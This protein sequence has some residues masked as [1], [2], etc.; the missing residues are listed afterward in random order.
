LEKTV[1]ID[2]KTK[3]SNLFNNF[4]LEQLSN[5]IKSARA[6]D[7]LGQFEEAISWYDIAISK[8][9]KDIVAWYNKG[10]I[11]DNLGRHNEAIHCYDRVI[12]IVPNDSSAMYNKATILARIGKLEEAVSLYDKIISIDPTHIGAL[13]NKR[14]TLDKLGMHYGIIQMKQRQIL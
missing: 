10:N 1:K 8:N 6:L 5:I 11:L 14:I 7:D 9:P 12:E 13:Y 3:F 2:K 4:N